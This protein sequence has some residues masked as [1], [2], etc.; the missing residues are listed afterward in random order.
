MKEN[1]CE[2]NT[3]KHVITDHAMKEK[4]SEWEETTTGQ[5]KGQKALTTQRRRE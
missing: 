2:T 4:W 1:R 5:L 3:N